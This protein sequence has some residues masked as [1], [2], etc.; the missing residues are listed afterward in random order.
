[1]IL[2]AIGVICILAAVVLAIGRASKIIW[3]EMDE[4]HLPA[5]LR[6]GK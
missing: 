1:M 5:V 3:E 4:K 6:R 2:L